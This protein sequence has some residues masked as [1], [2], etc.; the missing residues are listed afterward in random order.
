MSCPPEPKDILWHDLQED[1]TKQ[2]AKVLTGYALLTG[3]FFAYMPLVLA[4]TNLA[5][6]INLG[7]LQPIWASLAP[8]LGLTVMVSFLPSLLF[9]IFD[10]C[11]VLQSTLMAQEEVHKWYYFFQV[12][13]V[14]LATAVG[15]NVE[16]FIE[17]LVHDPLG[18]PAV[19]A[20]TMPYATHYYMNFLVLQWVSHASNI[21]RISNITKYF[22]FCKLYDEDTAKKK[23]EPEDQAYYG[24]GGRSARFT[25]N[26]A[27]G[28][29]FGTL[30]PPI[31]IL[32]WINFY[33]CRG[34]FGYM[35][36]FCETKKG[37]LGGVFFVTQLRGLYTA[38]MIYVIL[39]AAV[40]YQRSNSVIPGTIATA[41]FVYVFWAWKKFERSFLWEKIPHSQIFQTATKRKKAAG[42]FVQPE[43]ID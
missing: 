20:D 26:M 21:V 27:L 25:I 4:V 24:I 36:P 34:I 31:N 35:L 33:I 10:H 5:E 43:L 15:Q 14:I 32:V 8:T 9:L 11:W 23:A 39:M 41:S 19:M 13:F 1:P 22:T 6:I 18:I 12:I 17:T 29:V 40:L 30:S 37:D 28:I 38:M 7:P 16:G 2:G 42:A 3:L